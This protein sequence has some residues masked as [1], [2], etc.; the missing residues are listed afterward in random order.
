ML[1]KSLSS[2][3]PACASLRPFDIVWVM[4][5]VVVGMTIVFAGAVRREWRIVTERLCW[6]SKSMFKSFNRDVKD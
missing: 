6:L 4:C 2:T 5:G 1:H 3:C